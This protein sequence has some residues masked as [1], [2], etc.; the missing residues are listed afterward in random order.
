VTEKPNSIHAPPANAVGAAIHDAVNN[1]GTGIGEAVAGAASGNTQLENQGV[2]T[3]MATVVPLLIT[4]GAP[5]SLPDDAVVV[6]G[7]MNLPENF[8][9]GKGVTTD[10]SGNLQGVSVNSAAGKTATELSEGI[11][12]G[13]VGTT[14]VGDVRNAGGQVT[15]SPTANNPN[16]CTM[17]GITAKKASSLMKVQR[18]PAKTPPTPQ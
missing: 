10:A 9:S 1:V 14:T 13:Q 17:C 11:K 16:H 7:G 15:P 6:R 4:D 5:E 8:T 18:N 3:V 12:N 2:N